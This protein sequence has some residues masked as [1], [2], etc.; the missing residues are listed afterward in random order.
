MTIALKSNY[1]SDWMTFF[2]GGIGWLIYNLISFFGAFGPAMP[3]GDSDFIHAKQ[4]LDA[5]LMVPAF[6]AGI[7]RV[8]YLIGFLFWLAMF[9]H[10][11]IVRYYEMANVI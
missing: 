9:R 10:A 1:N 4:Y 11:Y 2:F 3:G 7:I 6:T 5:G 8:F